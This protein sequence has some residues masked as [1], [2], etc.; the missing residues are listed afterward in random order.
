MK[1]SATENTEPA[2]A[3]DSL[4][5]HLMA[6]DRDDDVLAVRDQAEQALALAS[7]SDVPTQVIARLQLLVGMAQLQ[8]AQFEAALAH[9]ATAATL[10]GSVSDLDTGS[11]AEWLC[12]CACRFTGRYVDALLHFQR[13]LELAHARG[14]VE[15]EL[16]LQ[17]MQTFLFFQ[18]ADADA[19][20]ASAE[21]AVQRAMA[22]PPPAPYLDVAAASLALARVVRSEFLEQ[23]G[24]RSDA[25][26]E[27]QMALTHLPDLSGGGHFAA[28]DAALNALSRLGRPDLAHAL[29]PHFIRARRA[30]QAGDL[31]RT[32]YAIAMAAYHAA[33][34]RPA[35]AR[36]LLAAAVSKMDASGRVSDLAASLQ[37]LAGL[38]AA[39]GDHRT[40]LTLMRRAEVLRERTD[41]EQVRLRNRLSALQRQVE[42]RHVERQS[43]LR[44]IQRLALI[45]RL[46]SQ[47]YHSLE[48]PL[49]EVRASLGQCIDHFSHMTSDELVHALSRVISNVDAAARLARQLKM[50][51]YRTAP[52]DMAANMT[53]ALKDAWAGIAGAS[54]AEQAPLV[55]RGDPLAEVRGDVQRL[56]VLLR[57]LFIEIE[58]LCGPKVPCVTVLAN[59]DRLT[60]TLEAPTLR[61]APLE[62]DSIGFTLCEEI[63]REMK[64]T[65]RG[66]DHSPGRILVELDLPAEV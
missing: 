32:D 39:S 55:P 20:V 48:A 46:M 60:V 37:R 1:P 5:G 42:E 7:Q 35:R 22:L 58:R 41:H 9:G 44:H 3:L 50:F 49:G 36:R 33:S 45:G 43:E 28:L 57:I 16:H 54:A 12:G 8:G 21:L 52:Q 31:R 26:R 56:A 23:Q 64:G 29:L 11:L 2:A 38:H 65:L 34:D 27:R 14:D 30:F 24:Q 40:A 18:A 62:A 25:E 6:L 10:A 47:I 53:R 59:A 61:P 19:A 66:F 17:V 15:H 4:L 13:S 63:A 51:S